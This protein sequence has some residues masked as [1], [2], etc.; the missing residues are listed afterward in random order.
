MWLAR[1]LTMELRLDHPL[2][3]ILRRLPAEERRR[4]IEDLL[5]KAQLALILSVPTLLPAMVIS[6]SAF[7][8]IDA[9]LGFGPAGFVL[10]LT[11]F[12]MP[13]WLLVIS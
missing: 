8:V 6:P 1:L 7:D 2:D 10:Y 13:A 12:V 9:N 4:L 3:R 11:I 5:D